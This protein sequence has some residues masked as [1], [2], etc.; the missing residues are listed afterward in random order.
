MFFFTKAFTV[1]FSLGHEGVVEYSGLEIDPA[2]GTFEFRGILE[3]VGELDEI[4]VPGTFVRVRVPIGEQKD[5]LLVSERA[6]G[7]DQNGRFVLVVNDDDVVEHRPV[8][9]GAQY[10]EQR[11][12]ETGLRAEDRVIVKGLQRARPGSKVAPEG[13]GSEGPVA[14]RGSDTAGEPP[15][16]FE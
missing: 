15:Q 6:L 1:F 5:A 14:A 12:I 10:G 9:L 4:I 2:T 3:N 11:L 8:Q 7:A 13:G 16:R